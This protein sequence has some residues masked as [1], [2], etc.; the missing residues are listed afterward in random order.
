MNRPIALLVDDDDDFRS[1]FGELLREEG[2]GVREASNGVEAVAALEEGPPDVMIVDLAMP[3]MSGWALYTTL[4][5]RR[6]LSGVPVVFLS[7][8]PELAPRGGMM[9]VAKPLNVTSLTALLEAIR[10]LV[11]EKH[12]S[13]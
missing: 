9:T 1:L 5:R 12:S 7:A 11:P 13:A 8:V 3:T 2:Y 10:P 6:D 4:R